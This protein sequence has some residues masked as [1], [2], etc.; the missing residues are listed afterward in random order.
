MMNDDD[1][2]QMNQVITALQVLFEPEPELVDFFIFK[3]ILLGS[4]VSN[5]AFCAPEAMGMERRLLLQA[6]MDIAYGSGGLFF[7]AALTH[8]SDEHWGA[9]I[10]S[11]ETLRGFKKEMKESDSDLIQ[12][13]SEYF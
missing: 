12:K 4:N 8:W 10:R 6:G 7:D 3:D 9:F 11:I 5:L 1:N 13:L 2:E